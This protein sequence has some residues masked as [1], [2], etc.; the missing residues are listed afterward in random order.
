MFCVSGILYAQAQDSIQ[1]QQ[2]LD[3]VKEQAQEQAKKPVQTQNPTTAEKDENYLYVLAEE[4]PEFN[5]G[6]DSM[7]IFL[8]KNMDYKGIVKDKNTGDKVFVEFVVEKNGSLSNALVV[9]SS[10]NKTFDKE[11]LRVVNK[12]PPWK[13]GLMSGNPVRTKLLIPIA[14]KITP[15]ITEK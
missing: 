3:S 4:M 7:H 8:N 5:G 13:P 11:A 6:I 2:V 15:K 12:M 14:F 9:R 10:G 1:D